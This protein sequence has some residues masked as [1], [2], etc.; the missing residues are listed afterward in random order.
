MQHVIPTGSTNR[1]FRQVGIDSKQM[2]NN[3]D[4]DIWVVGQF[5]I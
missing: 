4:L 2:A 5:E 1:K 3:N